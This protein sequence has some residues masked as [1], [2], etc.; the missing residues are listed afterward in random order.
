MGNCRRL[1]SGAII[2]PRPLDEPT[3]IEI[4]DDG[5]IILFEM[6]TYDLAQPNSAVHRQ[7]AQVGKSRAY[8]PSCQ[9][10]WGL[11]TALEEG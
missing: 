4:V 5:K 2:A 8:N 7:G 1:S 6:R 11:V 9:M 10:K 3:H